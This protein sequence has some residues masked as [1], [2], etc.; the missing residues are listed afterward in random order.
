MLHTQTFLQIIVVENS[1]QFLSRLTNID[2]S[3]L[4][5]NQLGLYGI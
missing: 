3:V 2:I 5:A 1:D 4:E